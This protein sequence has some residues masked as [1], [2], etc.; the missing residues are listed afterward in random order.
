MTKSADIAARVGAA[1]GNPFRAVGT[2]SDFQAALDQ[3]KATPALFALPSAKLAGEDGGMTGQTRQHVAAKFSLVIAVGNV[4]PAG[5]NQLDTIEDLEEW[6]IDVMVGWQPADMT[7]PFLYAG[8]QMVGVDVD[9]GVMFWGCD[10]A[11]GFFLRKG[12][13]T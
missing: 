3:L 5:G 1:D 10:F 6:L 8:G 11:S 7:E 2:A 12:T 4:G 13:S 9:K